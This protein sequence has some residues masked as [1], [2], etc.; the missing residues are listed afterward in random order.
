MKQTIFDDKRGP[1]TANRPLARKS[2]RVRGLP[3]A[4]E[5]RHI[6]LLAV[7]FFREVRGKRLRDGYTSLSLCRP[8]LTAIAA[9][10][11]S[12]SSLSTRPIFSRRRLLSKVR[13]CSKST[14]ESLVNP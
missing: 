2:I 1:P 11:L 5:G 12:I 6:F 7:G 14:T 9:S 4:P 8:K 3:S 10:T 13:I